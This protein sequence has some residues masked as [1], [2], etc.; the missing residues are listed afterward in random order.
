[1]APGQE[2]LVRLSAALAARDAAGLRVHMRRAA[3]MD[4]SVRVEEALLQSY[5]FLGF[6]AAL[7]G[8]SAWN[9]MS[10]PGFLEADPLAQTDS[11]ADWDRR[12][13]DVCRIVYG[14]TYEKLRRNVVRLHPAMDRW[15]ITEGY[16]KVLG[17][18]GLELAD[19]ELCIVALLTVAAW[20]PQLHSHLRGALN[21]GASPEAVSGAV[22]IGLEYV[23]DPDW[24]DSV[25]RLWRRVESWH[26]ACS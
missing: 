16:G 4:L 18:P 23:D 11:V 8:I 13:E 20:E 5:L 22:E 26:L 12:G 17:R 9:E 15:M 1:L 2:V 14:P 10:E 3:A 24:T 7:T 19:R 6:P 25:R 21:V